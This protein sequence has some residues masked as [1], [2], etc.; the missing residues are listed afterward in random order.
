LLADRYRRPKEDNPYPVSRFQRIMVLV[1]TA[2]LLFT[3]PMWI[4]LDRRVPYELDRATVEPGEARIGSDVF[5]SFYAKRRRLG[6][7][8]PVVVH[9]GLKDLASGEILS[10]ALP[11]PLLAGED[12]LTQTL[13]LPDDAPAGKVAYQGQVC[14][15]CN[16]LQSWLRWPVCMPVPEV[17]FVVRR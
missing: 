2:V 1:F 8:R 12:R 3:P 4:L 5:V 13:R 14:Y 16:I 15:T 7:C 9:R 11:A 17:E 10:V 6:E